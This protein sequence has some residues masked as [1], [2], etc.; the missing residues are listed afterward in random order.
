MRQVKDDVPPHGKSTG[1][2]A[3]RQKNNGKI[4]RRYPLCVPWWNNRTHSAAADEQ[5][6]Y[7]P[8]SEADTKKC[9][10][11]RTSCAGMVHGETTGSISSNNKSNESVIRRSPTVMPPGRGNVGGHKLSERLDAGSDFVAFVV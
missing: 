7:V 6:S 10:K 3:S 8:C 5:N 2:T 11:Q 4:M 1:L 9:D